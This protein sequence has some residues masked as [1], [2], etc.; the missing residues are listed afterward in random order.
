LDA[1]RDGNF[2]REPNRQW[3][4]IKEDHMMVLIAV[5]LAPVLF[6]ALFIGAPALER[7]STRARPTRQS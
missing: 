3:G 7:R 5:L 4:S 6:G 2:F 1:V